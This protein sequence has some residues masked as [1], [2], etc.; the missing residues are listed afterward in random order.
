MTALTAWLA[1]GPSL[2]RLGLLVVLAGLAP[3]A[4]SIIN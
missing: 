4:T 3:L 2:K 1:D